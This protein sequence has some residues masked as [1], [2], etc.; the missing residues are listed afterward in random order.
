MKFVDFLHI[1]FFILSVVILTYYSFFKDF[2]PFNLIYI[3]CWFFNSVVNFLSVFNIFYKIKIKKEIFKFNFDYI[4]EKEIIQK[5]NSKY[6]NNVKI[7]KTVVWNENRFHYFLD[8]KEKN[9][10]EGVMFNM[11]FLMMDFLS[12]NE[13]RLYESEVK[14][15]FKSP[16]L[17][18]RKRK[19]KK[20]KDD[21]KI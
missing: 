15:F 5:I 12:E 4:N 21:N 8:L 18:K 10:I 16:K 20:I 17:Y 6:F 3:F 2:E 11:P 14:K 13:Y 1:L 9:L 19:I 7:T